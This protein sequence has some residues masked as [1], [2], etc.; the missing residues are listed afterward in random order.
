MSEKYVQ[1]LLTSCKIVLKLHKNSFKTILTLK[2]QFEN[3]F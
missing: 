2:A 3:N 1:G